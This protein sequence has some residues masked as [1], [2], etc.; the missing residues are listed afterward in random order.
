METVW[1]KKLRGWN[2]IHAPTYTGVLHSFLTL[3]V[4]LLASM[5][6]TPKVGWVDKSKQVASVGYAGMEIP[7]D[8]TVS[9]KRIHTERQPPTLASPVDKD[10]HITKSM[11]LNRRRKDDA[12]KQYWDLD[13]DGVVSQRDLYLAK[14]FG[15]AQHHPSEAHVSI[16]LFVVTGS[17]LS[18]YWDRLPSPLP[19]PSL[20]CHVS[21]LTLTGAH[22]SGDGER[23][24]HEAIWIA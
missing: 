24:T 20:S 10:P 16:C 18:F 9:F 5:D 12:P 8:E 1:E 3:V 6:I 7:Q 11:L 15:I 2:L 14:Q 13:G 17:L 22:E 23:R 4:S 21:P 19:P